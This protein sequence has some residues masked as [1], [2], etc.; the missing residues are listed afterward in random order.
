MKKITFLLMGVMTAMFVFAQ[1]PQSFKY[2]AVLRDA[3]GDILADH[4]C[5]IEIGLLQGNPSAS[6]IYTE[7]HAVTTNEY[8]LINLNIGSGKTSDDFSAIN[9]SNGP[10]YLRIS[11]DGTLFGTSQILGVP[12]SIYSQTATQAQY[13]DSAQ[14]SAS[15]Q[16]GRSLIQMMSA[17]LGITSGQFTAYGISVQELYASGL[18]VNTLYNGG[19]FVQQMLD[20]GIG[21]AE[22]VEAD[23]PVDSLLAAGFTVTDLV[24]ANEDVDDM[25]AA[26]ITLTELLEAGVSVDDLLN[27]GVTVA[28]LVAENVSV[29]EMLVAGVTIEQLIDANEDV[30]DMLDVGISVHHLVMYG[31]DIGDML[32]AGVNVLDLFN[33]G[34]MV[35]TLVQKG[36]N[37]DS[38]IAEGLIGTTPPDGDGN[39][40]N[41]VRIGDQ[42]WM[43]QDMKAK[44]YSNGTA[45]LDGTGISTT[46]DQLKYYYSYN[47]DTANAETYGYLYSWAA[48]TN[49]VSSS[50]NPSGV[51]GICPTGWHI[52][53]DGEWK[54]LEMELGMSQA[55]ANATGYRGTDEGIKLKEEGISHWLNFPTNPAMVGNNESGFT[56]LPGGYKSTS[57]YNL[58]YNARYWA[59]ETISS[60]N[61]SAFYRIIV[62]SLGSIFRSNTPAYYSFSVRCVKD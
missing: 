12:Y 24:G 13:S 11:V 33:E 55:D 49:G 57:F 3:S 32:L 45:L 9:W 52:P 1:T 4:N 48:A 59:T 39:V 35:G 6:S 22:L 26:G 47:D 5:S 61:S 10:Y 37:A 21:I 56:A 60:T 51:Q 42:I 18:S 36:A 17:E 38:L 15:S 8:G 20:I 27:G 14:F 40:Y 53:S 46:D 44:H 19:V 28:Q 34:I 23:L 43:S 50:S 25:L 62:H 29:M 41:W 58:T 7:T 16:V 31:E 2:Q 54:Q 30:A